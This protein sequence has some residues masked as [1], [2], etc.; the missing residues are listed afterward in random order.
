MLAEKFGLDFT[1]I[2]KLLS[3]GSRVIKNCREVTEA[4]KLV[5]ALWAAGW[6]A[7]IQRT[8]NTTASLS[9]S[10]SDSLALRLV[11]DD[12]SC[13]VSVPDFWRV[14]DDLNHRAVLQAGS[15]EN[16]EFM[17]VLPQRVEDFRSAP[18]V[19]EYC[20]AQ[21]SQCATQLHRAA[22]SSPPE[23][24]PLDGGTGFFGE[25]L[26]EVDTV[27]VQYLVA[28]IGCDDRI[29]TLFLWCEQGVFSAR[30]RV[31]DQLIASFTGAVKDAPETNDKN[32]K[33]AS[34]DVFSQAALA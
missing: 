30:R 19:E 4:E 15:L 6:H 5:Q 13:A 28:C 8:D 12:G 20:C 24:L 32:S 18:T 21:L 11:S 29:Y 31:F 23:K 9:P 1:Q 17:V 3:G 34:H 33:N 7:E 16:N 26:A 2:K 10:R 14:F 27:P 22:V 25:L